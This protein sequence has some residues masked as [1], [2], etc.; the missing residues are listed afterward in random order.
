MESKLNILQA[1]RFERQKDCLAVSVEKELAAG[2]RESARRLVIFSFEDYCAIN[3]PYWKTMWLSTLSVPLET[4]R[5]HGLRGLP[6]L[7]QH[8]AVIKKQQL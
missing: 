4:L 7:Q 8:I 3:N 1:E 2:N 5:Q 6:D